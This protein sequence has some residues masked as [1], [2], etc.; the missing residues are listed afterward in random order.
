M[1]RTPDARMRDNQTKRIQERISNVEKHFGKM[2]Q[3][4]AAY[5]RNSARV[6][7]KAD[8]LVRELGQYSDTETPSLKNALKHFASHLAKIQDY[9]QAQVERLEVKVIEPLKGYNA[10]VR[11]KREDVKTTQSART[12]ESKQMDQLERTRQKNPSD[13]QVISQAES[14]LQRATMDATRTT[15]QLEET[16][17]EFEK[18][19][20]RDLKKILSDF[21]TVEMSFHAKALELYTL[22]YHS[23]HSVEEEEDLK[24]FRSSL[25]PPDYLTPANSLEGTASTPFQ[26]QRASGRQ[27]SRE[28]EEEDEDE[29]EEEEDEDSEEES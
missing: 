7:D 13:R 29:S 22:A 14:D 10:V 15:R 6:R 1:S 19:K 21:V 12:R 28:E 5:G 8:L 11:R 18:Q 23:I 25:H 4:L 20:M 27:A 24:V 3:T 26:Q 16:M 17:E 9:R 2:C